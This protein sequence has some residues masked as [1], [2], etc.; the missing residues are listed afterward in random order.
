MSSKITVIDYGVGNLLSVC[1]ALEHCGV[2]VEVVSSGAKILDASH[3]VL[4]GVGAFADGMKSLQNLSLI[5]PIREYA[6]LNRPM[7]GIC[8]GM[9][10]LLDSS[11]EFGF[12]KG[13]GLIP[14][15][16]K[17]IPHVSPDGIK[18]KIPHIGWNKLLL[19][20]QRTSWNTTILEG[21]EIKTYAYFVHSFTAWPDNP[22][23]RLADS[24]YN[25]C[26][27]SA[28]INLGSIYG[29]Q[30]HPEK[31]GGI[32]LKILSDFIRL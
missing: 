26:L 29:C 22:Q 30:F 13:L 7:L 28:A 16:V 10:M 20:E 21:I 8:L 23:H 2:S 6:G 27:L 3:L 18:H 11:E 5:E 1:R 15:H 24:Y 14:G 4:P 19:P 12:S 9:Q 17:M 32:G 25:G 31:S